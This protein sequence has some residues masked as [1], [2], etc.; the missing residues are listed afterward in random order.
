MATTRV[1]RTSSVP[2]TQ[3]GFRNVI[4]NGDFR[5]NQ[6]NYIKNTNLASGA[7]GF[8]RWKSNFTNTSLNFVGSPRGQSI[9]ISSGGGLQQVI[10]QANIVAGT[11]TLSWT[12]TAT[13][14]IYNSE[15]PP[16]SYAAS[17]ITVAI[18]DNSNIVVEF[19]ANGGDKTLHNVQFEQGSI[20]TPF[21]KRPIGL[22]LSLCQ[23]YFVRLYD[24]S[25][26]GVSN[27]GTA[28]GATR[29]TVGLPV[30]MRVVPTSL[31]A[32]GTFSFWDG[33][34]APTGTLSPTSSFFPSKTSIEVEFNLSSAITAGKA[35]KMYTSNSTSKWLDVNAEL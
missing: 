13:G 19:T 5:I 33:S 20:A 4:I 2:S 29:V 10:E 8:D 28:N 35:V 26:T 27:G 12:G 23:R 30:E 25:G 7:Y 31:T 16:T 34:T 3:T 22:E 9:T 1:F 11:Y 24:P 6:R 18:N 21:E 14:R 32:N 17:P 15:L